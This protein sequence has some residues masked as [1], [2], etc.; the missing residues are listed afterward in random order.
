M[1]IHTLIEAMDS[2][3]CLH[4]MCYR[5][6]FT[7]HTTEQVDGKRFRFVWFWLYY[8]F[9]W[10]IP[11][12]YSSG[13]ATHRGMIVNFKAQLPWGILAKLTGIKS[14]QTG[15]LFLILRSLWKQNVLFTTFNVWSRAKYICILIWNYIWCDNGKLFE[16]K[17]CRRGTG[18][19]LYID[20]IHLQKSNT[21]VAGVIQTYTFRSKRLTMIP[22]IASPTPIL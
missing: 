11:L 4:A 6:T 17:C 21:S 7:P 10:L 9:M 13:I 12:T 3:H 15:H 8:Q 18:I 1:N 20:S 5:Y 2:P 19:Y 16:P 14:Q 22:E